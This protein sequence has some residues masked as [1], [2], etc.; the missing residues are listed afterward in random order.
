MS[1]TACVWRSWWGANRR[2]TP[3][4]WISL[5]AYFQDVEE[6]SGKDS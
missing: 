4:F 1:S 3:A 5:V 6:T 2:L